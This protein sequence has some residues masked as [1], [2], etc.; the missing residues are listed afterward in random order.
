MIITDL[1]YGDQPIERVYLNNK[2]VWERTILTY[3]QLYSKTIINSYNQAQIHIVEFIPLFGENVSLTFGASVAKTFKA[4]VFLGESEEF[5][6]A[7]GKIQ[8]LLSCLLRGSSENNSYVKGSSLSF[9]SK[10]GKANI[11]IITDERGQISLSGVSSIKKNIEIITNGTVKMFFSDAKIKGEKLEIISTEKGE[12]L[13][14]E[15]KIREGKITKKFYE[16]AEPCL[17]LV[18][19]VSSKI[20]TKFNAKGKGLGAEA[21]IIAKSLENYINASANGYGGI[22]KELSSKMPISIYLDVV[23]YVC[24]EKNMVGSVSEKNFVKIQ[25]IASEARLSEGISK[26]VNFTKTKGRFF[27]GIF[28][29]HSKAQT[30]IYG[31]GNL[32]ELPSTILKG[33]GTSNLIAISNSDAEIVVTKSGQI[34]LNFLANGKTNIW[35]PPIEDGDIL[36]IRQAFRIEE[37]NDIMEVI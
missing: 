6:E 34:E 17:C 9:D 24:V 33:I 36:E 13:S 2:I 31:K 15:T 30:S 1:F 12:A 10:N 11:E 35:Y 37:E 27:P 26:V 32:K 16:K 23:G 5:T 29:K 3:A 25:G 7:Q 20:I 19:F 4:V 8:E 28:F 14:A 22:R 21:K 18:P